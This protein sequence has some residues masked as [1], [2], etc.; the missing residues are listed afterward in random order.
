MRPGT[1][2]SDS[3]A[4]YY[5]SRLSLSLGVAAAAEEVQQFGAAN[6]DNP[7]RDV[8]S[9]LCSVRSSIAERCRRTRSLELRRPRG[10]RRARRDGSGNASLPRLRRRRPARRVRRRRSGMIA[11]RCP[12]CAGGWRAGRGRR[13]GAHASPS[14]LWVPGTRFPCK[15]AHSQEAIRVLALATCGLRQTDGLIEA[16]SSDSSAA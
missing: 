2:V 5:L 3:P 9:R 13:V 10:Q 7:S 15:S 8:E 1:A 6:R 4:P 11:S 16:C 14:C 12:T